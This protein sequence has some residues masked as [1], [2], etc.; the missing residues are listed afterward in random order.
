MDAGYY[1]GATR[2]QRWIALGL[3]AALAGCSLTRSSTV[4]YPPLSPPPTG[5]QN[6]YVA[7]AEAKLSAGIAADEAGDPVAIDYYYAAATESWPRHAAHAAAPSD[8]AFELYRA[9]VRK[10]L[11]AAASA[12]SIRYAVSRSAMASRFPSA[13]SASCG[14]PR[15]FARFCPSVPTPRVN[16]RIATRRPAWASNTSC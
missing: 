2:S 5:N 12:G 15:T 10:L 8:A 9:A 1:R 6:V 16:S 11:D 3:L 7:S 13:T 4:W 14:S